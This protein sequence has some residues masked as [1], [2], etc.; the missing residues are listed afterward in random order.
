M[1][2]KVTHFPDYLVSPDGT[3]YS[4]KRKERKPLSPRSIN[5]YYT[6]VLMQDGK[7]YVK[8]VHKLIAF[9][10]IHNDD[11]N[12]KTQVIHKD[13]DKTNND[14]SNLEWT[15]KG[16]GARRYFSNTNVKR[17]KFVEG[18]NIPGTVL[19]GTDS[20]RI[21]PK[22][23][24]EHLSDSELNTKVNTLSKQISNIKS[25]YTRKLMKLD[26]EYQKQIQQLKLHY[27]TDPSKAK[28]EIKEVTIQHQA[29]KEKIQN[30]LNREIRKYETQ[31][32]NAF[33]TRQQ[34]NKYFYY[35][36]EYHKIT[37]TGKSLVIRLKDKDG[38]WT[39]LS[40]ARIIME[41]YLKRPQPTPAHRI[42]FK[43]FD[44]R[45]ITPINMLWETPKEKSARFHEMF[46][47]KALLRE[48]NT[49]AANHSNKPDKFHDK[50][51]KLLVA[52]NNYK[53]VARKLEI[54]Y[55]TLYR[56]CKDQGI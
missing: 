22:V 48:K 34:L 47:Y 25:Q 2:K 38:N 54:P 31:K 20:Y 45:N 26:V 24:Q 8:Y 4:D 17:N 36:G 15:K 28:K 43:D 56:Y 41:K 16:E 35:N 1:L 39:M 30:R 37:D 32:T 18:D 13:G 5:G 9:E 3:V 40:L 52:G 19:Y 46:P 10:F 44:Y 29:N 42:G 51:V 53:Q 12:E 6:V 55:Y 11:P 49:K 7:Q 21:E 14:V 27:K 50:I 33:R 23:V